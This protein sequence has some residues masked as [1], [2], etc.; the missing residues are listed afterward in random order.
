MADQTIKLTSPIGRNYEGKLRR[1][2]FRDPQSG[3]HYVFLTNRFDLVA[4]T[5]CNLYKAR[6]QVELFF[7]NMKQHLQ[8]KKF[9]GTSVNAVKIQIWV[10]LIAYLLVMMIK[11]Q[12]RLDWYTPSI[13]AVLTVMLFS[14]RYLSTIWKEVPKVRPGISPPE[15]LCLF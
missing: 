1:V 7:K 13:M 2:S 6:W 9:I 12:N 11:Y 15:Q 4:K 8:I 5:I 3:Q 10:A 14:S